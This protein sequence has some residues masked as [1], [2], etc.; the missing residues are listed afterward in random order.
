MSTLKV[1]N[2]NG[3]TGST[4]T[5]PAGQ[6][7]IVNTITVAD[8]DITTNSSNADL[9]LPT[10]W[11]TFQFADGDKIQYNLTITQPANFLPAWAS[12]DGTPTATKYRMILNVKNPS[13]DPST[14]W[15]T[16]TV[17]PDR[18]AELYNPAN[19][20]NGTEG[21]GYGYSELN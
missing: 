5:V 16:S 15:E 13:E 17:F 20:A 18:L 2:L 8:N 9:N 12:N 1:D 3:S 7:L 10:G 21:G 19:Y 4:I 6:S 11:R 14:G